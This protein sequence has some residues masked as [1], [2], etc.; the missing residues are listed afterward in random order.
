MQVTKFS[1]YWSVTCYSICISEVVNIILTEWPIQFQCWYQL[2]SQHCIPS[3]GGGGGEGGYCI[4][5]QVLGL[6][7]SFE[8]A[9]HT[10]RS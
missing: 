3:S 8:I 2:T 4:E 5:Q 9:G 10:R 6:S 1:I 7:L